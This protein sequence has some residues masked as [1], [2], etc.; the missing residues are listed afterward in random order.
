MTRCVVAIPG[1][2]ATPTGGYAYARKVLPLLSE[3]METEICHLPAGFPFPSE[4]ELGETALALRAADRTGTVFLIDGLAFGAL[5]ADLISALRSPIAALV[6]HPLGF[7][8]GFGAEAKA[9]LL[10]LEGQALALAAAAVVPSPGTAR[11]LTQLLGVPAGKI[12]VAEPGVLRGRRAMGTL[13]GE[14][15]HIVSA[16]TL[17]PRKG[18]DVLAG[19][20]GEISALPW[21]ATIAGS[22]DLSPETAAD[23]RRKIAASG[24]EERVRFVG[25]VNEA[26]VSALYS[27]G[28]IFALASYYEGYGMVFAE[29]MA[30]G[31]PI[32]ASGD[33][34]V[35]GTV[36]P[37]AGFVCAPGDVHAI[38]G[39][40]RAF[41]CGEDLRR[42]KAEAAWRHGQTLPA[43]PDTAAIIAG[44]LERIALR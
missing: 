22:L 44:V 42:S 6:H 5:P 24:L 21:S 37:E 2:L 33:G 16:G 13:A 40:L 15:L 26:A 4:A 27:S 30:H 19:A 31:L 11:E 39:A 7:E 43:W 17:T 18:F 35:A 8:E 14:P 36:P 25:H 20:L 9:R 3:R 10:D 41:L 29:A 38:A 32:V 1:D 23:V 28:D 12:T 34:A